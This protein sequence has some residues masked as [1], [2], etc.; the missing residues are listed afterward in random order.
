MSKNIANF[1]SFLWAV[2]ST[3]LKI[4]INILFY[5]YQP[6]LHAHRKELV[7]KIMALHMCKYII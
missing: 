6:K 3:H 5:N 1:I 4:V 7:H 2:E